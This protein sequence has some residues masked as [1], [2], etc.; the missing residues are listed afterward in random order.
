MTAKKQVPI[1]SR[2]FTYGVTCF[3]K[4]LDVIFNKK[5]RKKKP[6]RQ[7]TET[8]SKLHN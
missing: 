2:Y 5:G 8:I 3:K 6:E 4:K 7:T 1:N